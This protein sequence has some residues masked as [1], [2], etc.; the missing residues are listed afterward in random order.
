MGKAIAAHPVFGFVG[1]GLSVQRAYIAPQKAYIAKRDTHAAAYS[2]TR[3]SRACNDRQKAAIARFLRGRLLCKLATFP[4]PRELAV[5]GR[6]H[7][8]KPSVRWRP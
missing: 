8:R 2:V 3:V 7:T 6:G 1:G 5:A 4:V